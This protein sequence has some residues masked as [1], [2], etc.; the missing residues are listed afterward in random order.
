MGHR[1]ERQEAILQ[2]LAGS[3]PGLD[4]VRGLSLLVVLVLQEVFLRVLW[5]FPSPR[6]GTLAKFQFDL[7]TVDE[8]RPS[9][10]VHCQLPFN[11][12]PHPICLK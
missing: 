6:K 10:N 8:E 5:F 9:V 11:S 4:I 7:D 2:A 3:I 12:H 1:K